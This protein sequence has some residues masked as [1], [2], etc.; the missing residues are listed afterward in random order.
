MQAI[1][2]GFARRLLRSCAKNGSRYTRAADVGEA[3]VPVPFRF[4]CCGLP[5]PSSVM[6]TCALS[7]PAG[8]V[9]EKVTVIVQLAWA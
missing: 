3:Y 6:V 8:C 4:T 5:P 1:K 2:Q 9:G 7:I